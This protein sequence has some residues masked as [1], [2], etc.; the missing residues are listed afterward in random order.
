[1]KEDVLDIYVSI[2][3]GMLHYVII[4]KNMMIYQMKYIKKTKYS[5]RKARKNINTNGYVGDVTMNETI[6]DL[7]DAIKEDKR[8]LQFKEQSLKLLNQETK[9]LLDN[10]Q[11]LLQRIR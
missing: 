5:F 3:F 8:Y 2:L 6:Y 11:N 1:M 10:Y 7:I 9:E 4:Q